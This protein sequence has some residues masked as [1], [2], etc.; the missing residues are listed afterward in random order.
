M[1][2]KVRDRRLT[3]R[4]MR[5]ITSSWL[6]FF[7]P[8]KVHITP[9][10]SYYINEL[11]M[12]SQKHSFSAAYVK[13][14]ELTES[15]KSKVSTIFFYFFYGLSINALLLYGWNE[16]VLRASLLWNGA[17]IFAFRT[18]ALFV[19][20]CAYSMCLGPGMFPAQAVKRH[21][22]CSFFVLVCWE[23]IFFA[24]LVP[25]D[26]VFSTPTRSSIRFS[27]FV[28]SNGSVL[29]LRFLESICFRYTLHLIRHRLVCTYLE[30]HRSFAWCLRPC[31]DAFF[32]PSW[33]FSW[34]HVTYNP[35]LAWFF[36]VNFAF[37]LRL[38]TCFSPCFAKIIELYFKLTR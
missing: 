26:P 13:V 23:L 16:F 12:L 35:P 6:S 31:V 20:L 21:A 32:P 1:P 14:E 28:F 29:F 27:S 24:F 15:G 25:E 10:P 18:T 7:Q 4:L 5:A 22:S 37:C 8:A 2:L 19:F 38:S 33:L 36:A 17:L 30:T 3:F 11:S 9:P 34:K